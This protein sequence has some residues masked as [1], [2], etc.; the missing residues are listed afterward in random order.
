M[1]QEFVVFGGQSTGSVCV[2]AALTIIGAP[3]RVEAGENHPI[4]P[5]RQVPALVLPSGELMTESA[6][7]L[8]WL[9]DEFPGVGLAPRIGEPSRAAYLRWMAFVSAA[10]Y[11]L[12]WI[13]DEPGPMAADNAHEGALRARIDHRIAACWEIMEKQISPGRY[14]LGDSLTVLDLYVT[15]LSRWEP[16]RRRFY[17]VAPRMG[18]VVRHVDD[19]PRLAALWAER[20]LFSPGWDG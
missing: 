4:N 3:Y 11:S 1:T 10:I 19:D 18:D 8:I 12:Y 6:A 15:I 5:M 7:I 16:H 13:R 9:A 2:E 20:F 14:L 17:E